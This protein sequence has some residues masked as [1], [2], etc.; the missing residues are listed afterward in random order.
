[1]QVVILMILNGEKNGSG[2]DYQFTIKQ[3]G[4]EFKNQFTCL[5]G[6][7]KK[8]ITFT[9]SIEKEVSQID[10]NGKKLHKTQNVSAIL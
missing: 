1:M 9:N 3:F 6:K 8:Y 5:G 4:E 7:T 2:Y 10:K